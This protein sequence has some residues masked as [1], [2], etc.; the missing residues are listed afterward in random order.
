ML[1][2]LDTTL[3][4][5]VTKLAHAIQR[6]NDNWHCYRIAEQLFTVGCIAMMVVTLGHWIP[7]LYRASLNGGGVVVL[8]F[9][10]VLTTFNEARRAG[11]CAAAWSEREVLP[12][13]ATIAHT[14]FA[15]SFRL[16]FA[17]FVVTDVV[18]DGVLW[19]QGQL[20]VTSMIHNVWLFG[21]TCGQHFMA[22]TPMPKARLKVLV[23]VQR[24]GS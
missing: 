6:L 18:I 7:P 19:W 23:P 9:I 12:T 15:R 3:V 24:M 13:E 22:V 14:A 17:F 10:C 20:H 11:R 4:G 1:Q 8:S 2:H 21:Y 16:L 5:L